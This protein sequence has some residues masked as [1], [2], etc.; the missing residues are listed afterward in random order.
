MSDKMSKNAPVEIQYDFWDFLEEPEPQP[1]P[2]GVAAALTKPE[3]P[4][5]QSE[6]P[7]TP[8]PAPTSPRKPRRSRSPAPPAPA[9]TWAHGFFCRSA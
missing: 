5:A 8:A 1:V 2:G 7:Q 4:P 9:S 3:M 6:I